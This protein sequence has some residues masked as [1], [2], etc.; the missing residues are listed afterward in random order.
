MRRNA[1]LLA[2]LAF[3]GDASAQGQYGHLY[4]P[5]ELRL[6]QI[7]GMEV[8]TTEGRRLGRITELIFDHATGGIEEV[9]LGA[10][11]YP[12]GSLVSGTEPG[13]VLLEPPLESAA[14]ASALVPLSAGKKASGTSRELG[15]PSE[16]IVD[17]LEGRIRPRH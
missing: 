4:E 10:A 11:R 15:A 9:A 3:L 13:R 8:V 1:M 12:V 17:L 14:G 6:D 16:I 7:I 2:A 5:G